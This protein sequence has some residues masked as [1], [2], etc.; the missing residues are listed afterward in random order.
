MV[1]SGGDLIAT[2]EIY[3]AVGTLIKSVPVNA[4]QYQIDL[5][6][7]GAGSYFVKVGEKVTMV[8]KN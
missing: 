7:L 4:V 6:E 1:E 8:V 3:N 5:S 2:V